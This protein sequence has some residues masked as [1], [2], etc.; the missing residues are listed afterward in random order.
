MCVQFLAQI[1]FFR[2][3]FHHHPTIVVIDIL[4]KHLSKRDGACTQWTFLS[5]IRRLLLF[6]KL[7]FL[8]IYIFIRAL[9]IY[10]LFLIGCFLVAFIVFI[11]AFFNLWLLLLSVGSFGFILQP[12]TRFL[13]L[14][15]PTAMSLLLLQSSRLSL[16]LNPILSFWKIEAKQ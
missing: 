7:L 6:H 13:W 1:V 12:S 14:I 10:L 4:L 8:I 11:F 15:Q 5:I 3:R 9:V 16:W 2:F